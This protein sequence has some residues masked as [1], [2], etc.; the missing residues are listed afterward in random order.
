M[1]RAGSSGRKWRAAGLLAAVLAG[2]AAAQAQP[3][4]PGDAQPK[5]ALQQLFEN[6]NFWS[7]KGQPQMAMQELDRVL[8]LAPSDADS[9][10]TAARIAFQ[11]GQYEAGTRYRQ[12]LQ[13]IA[14]SDPRLPS[15]AAERLLSAA[16]LQTLSDARAA[17]VAGRKAEA[18]RAYRDIFHGSPTPDSLAVEYYLLLGTM[19]EV[20]YQQASQALAAVSARWPADPS[21]KLAYAQLETYNEGAR[22][23]GIDALQQLTQ[24]PAV[25]SGARIAWRDALMW[26]GADP[27]T[28]DQV[29]AYLN[30]N[31]PDPQLQ[32]KLKE[33]NDELPDEG[34]LDRMRAYEAGAAGNRD[35]EEQGFLAALQHDP[36]DAEAMIMLSIIRRRQGRTGES[37]GLIARAMQTAPDRRDEFIKD[38]GFD[39]AVLAAQAAA[40]PPIAVQNAASGLA[41]RRAYQRVSTLTQQGEFA[42]AE[43]ALRKLMG[44]HP[45]AGSYVQLGYIQLRAGRLADAEASFRRTLASSPRNPTALGGLAA[46]YARQGRDLEANAIYTRLGRNPDAGDALQQRATALRAQAQASGDPVEKARLYREASAAAP[47]DPWIKLEFARFLFG[48][49]QQ[50]DANG[51]M[52]G[53]AAGP[54]PPA[55]QVQAA[56][57]W[58]QEHDDPARVARLVAD[59]PAK[60][61]TPQVMDVAARSALALAI[62]RAQSAGSPAA[63][64][65]ALIAAAAQPDPAGARVQAVA[66]ALIRNG[67]KAAVRDAVRAGLSST[68]PPTPMQRLLYAGALSAAGLEGDARALLRQVDAA[69]L[70]PGQRTAYDSLADGL[71][72]RR[73]DRLDQEGRRADAYDA[74]SPRLRADPDSVDVNLAVSRLYSSDGKPQQALRIAEAALARSPSDLDAMHATADAALQAGEVVRARDLAVAAIDSQPDDPRGYLIQADVARFRN[75]SGEALAALRKARALRQQQLRQA[76]Q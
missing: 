38:I 50:A 71:A 59:L 22:A 7:E 35:A 62:G 14:P 25:A 23:D 75:Q 61:R 55:E 43:A 72:I 56:L 47:S 3:A 8:T 26:Q 31:F 49:A 63:V 10:A 48:H 39:P 68:R 30:A 65:A 60:L 66:Q 70:P 44:P 73:A 2:P 20:A 69:N 6:V 24:V 40:P 34:L 5:T 45:A 41:I 29:T 4:P 51:L 74:L 1:T 67:D 17:A 54:K 52:A 21:F 42:V 27:R 76:A 13:K 16:D 46:V 15:L 32:A 36:D 9:L 58:A 57:I 37:D 11:N 28:R 12:Q 64:R 19:S 53:V 18:V 33:M